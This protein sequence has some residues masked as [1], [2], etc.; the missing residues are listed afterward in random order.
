MSTG[1]SFIGSVTKGA[2]FTTGSNPETEWSRR[3]SVVSW[4]IRGRVPENTAGFV[5]AKQDKAGA[6]GSLIGS[7]GMFGEEGVRGGSKG[8]A[9][10]HAS[11]MSGAFGNLV[12]SM[13]TGASFIGSAGGTTSHSKSNAQPC[14]P[15]D[16]NPQDQQ[17]VLE[18]VPMD[19][20]FNVMRLLKYT[21]GL[22]PSL[23]ERGSAHM[24]DIVG[25]MTAR[26][27]EEGSKLSSMMGD[28]TSRLSQGRYTGYD[29][30][31]ADA[32]QGP[33][34]PANATEQTV[35]GR[36]DV[37]KDASHVDASAHRRWDRDSIPR[38]QFKKSENVCDDS[39]WSFVRRKDEPTTEEANGT[40]LEGLP[41]FQIPD[42]LP[43][44]LGTANGSRGKMRPDFARLPLC[45]LETTGQK[46]ARE[47][48]MPERQED[49]KVFLRDL[50]DSF[51]ELDVGHVAGQTA[52]ERPNVTWK[53]PLRPNEISG[54]KLV[55][56][57]A[58]PL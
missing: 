58:R 44:T 1:A 23:G 56:P 30:Q 3:P 4:N 19:G 8:D 45:Y 24:E 34:D 41:S 17:S 20:G 27:G 13:S 32:L 48:R 39:G 29:N 9:V 40:K 35:L 5:S 38:L 6:F 36:S 7:M 10:N 50:E 47:A 37:E 26:A 25:S 33:E 18:K 55:T 49:P 2:A 52:R 16:A 11:R 43:P 54:A 42:R 28:L 51:F 15:A 21:S 53:R 31:P 46:V 12:G 22:P 14:A 57:N